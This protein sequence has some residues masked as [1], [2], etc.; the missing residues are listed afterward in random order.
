MIILS[1]CSSL[2]KNCGFL[3]YFLYTVKL[4]KTNPYLDKTFI[5]ML[6]ARG[7]IDSLSELLIGFSVSGFYGVEK[8]ART[9][10]NTDMFNVTVFNETTETETYYLTEPCTIT[11]VG[12]SVN[13]GV[14]PPNVEDIRSVSVVCGIYVILTLIRIVFLVL[15]NALLDKL[16]ATAKQSSASVAP[17]NV[18]VVDEG[19]DDDKSTASVLID[20]KEEESGVVRSR[21]RDVFKHQVSDVSNSAAKVFEKVTPLFLL[22]SFMMALGSCVYSL[23]SMAFAVTK[24]GVEVD[25]VA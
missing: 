8:N 18:V 24:E 20:P 23:E 7:M 21:K 16:E 15:E 17:A 10:D 6:R 5:A 19:D 11:C 12:W 1:E 3:Q 9:W 13:D 25:V 4:R 2:C 14:P 22:V